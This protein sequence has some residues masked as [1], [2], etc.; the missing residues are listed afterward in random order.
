MADSPWLRFSS[1]R[2]FE[3]EQYATRASD[4]SRFMQSLKKRRSFSW[5]ADRAPQLKAIYKAGQEKKSVVLRG[6]PYGFLFLPAA[7]PS[8]VF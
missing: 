8:S 5:N 1:R 4:R 2:L 3:Q 7:A 6:V